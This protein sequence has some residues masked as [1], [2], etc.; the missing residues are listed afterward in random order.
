MNDFVSL[1]FFLG[2]DY[3]G[4]FEEIEQV[5]NSFEKIIV[6]YI[7]LNSSGSR[8]IYITYNGTFDKQIF[9]RFVLALSTKFSGAQRQKQ[10]QINFNGKRSRTKNHQQQQRQQTR[11]NDTEKIAQVKDLLAALKWTYT[12]YIFG[13]QSSNYKLPNLEKLSLQDFG[14]LIEYC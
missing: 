3:I 7:S 6:T 13:Q 11:Y 8:Y 1:S 14:K 10:P 4:Q 9:Q 2:N 12:Y 5:R